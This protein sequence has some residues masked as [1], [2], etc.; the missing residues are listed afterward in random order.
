MLAPS[1]E[2]HATCL[3][4]A[5]E[6]DMQR[7]LIDISEKEAVNLQ[8]DAFVVI[9]RDT[10]PSSEKLSQSVIDGVTVLGGQFHDYGL[11]TTPQLHYMVYCRNTGGRY[12]KA[13]IEG[14]YQK[15]SKAFV[16]LTKQASCSGDEY[17]SL[18]VDCAN[19]IGALKLREMEHYFSQG[20]S[21]QLFNDGSK[22]KLNHLCGAD[23]V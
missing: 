4:N 9:G 1:W 12:G 7:V 3:A 2:E 17:R 13:T 8:Q 23:F 6:Q 22:G 14:Y 18:K 16:E 15:L 5:E 21:V 10:R 19:G 11:L 20:L